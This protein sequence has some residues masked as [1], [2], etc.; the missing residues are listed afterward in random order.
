MV[1]A[2]KWKL[3]GLKLFSSK[4]KR[5]FKKWFCPTRKNI[6]IYFLL[7]NTIIGYWTRKCSKWKNL[8]IN[9]TNF[10]FFH[11]ENW[12]REKF[13]VKVTYLIVV[14][15]RISACEL[16]SFVL[17]CPSINLILEQ[18]VSLKAFLKPSKLY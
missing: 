16:L 17:R 4:A 8:E 13:T 12:G 6:Y 14:E 18:L 5:L 9:Q 7:E 15:L 1:Y 10:D 2:A 3:S 11:Y